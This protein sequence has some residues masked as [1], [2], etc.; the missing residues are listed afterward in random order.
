VLYT[1]RADDF[2]GDSARPVSKYLFSVLQYGW[3]NICEN[4]AGY[5]NNITGE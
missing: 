5:M 1:N 2:S 3:I 4:I